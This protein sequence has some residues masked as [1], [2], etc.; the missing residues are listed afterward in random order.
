M[1]INTKKL[2][3]TKV[4]CIM[5]QKICRSTQN[6]YGDN[7]QRLQCAHSVMPSDFQFVNANV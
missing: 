3:P 4:L 6:N 2:L 1:F 7:A 5:F